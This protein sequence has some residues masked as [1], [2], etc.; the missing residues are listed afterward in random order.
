MTTRRKFIKD[1][2]L[3]G[4]VFILPSFK[5]LPEHQS[6]KFAGGDEDISLSGN[7]HFK[8]DP[9]NKGITQQWQKALFV[10]SARLPGSA[11]T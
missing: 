1:T 2:V 6:D 9:E 8:L 4:A 3:G 11:Q 7:W 10:D 5:L